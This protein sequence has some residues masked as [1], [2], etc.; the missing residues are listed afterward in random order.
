MEEGPSMEAGG[1]FDR[2]TRSV[3]MAYESLETSVSDTRGTVVDEHGYEQR[4]PK[5]LE[6]F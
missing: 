5:K 3:S 1:I 4:T 2:A 6:S